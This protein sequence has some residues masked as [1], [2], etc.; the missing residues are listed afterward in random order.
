MNT[1]SGRHQL[2]PLLKQVDEL[3]SALDELT[4]TMASFDRGRDPDDLIS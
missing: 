1:A 2:A 4:E 3:N